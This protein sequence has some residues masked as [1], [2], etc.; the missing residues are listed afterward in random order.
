MVR[1][2]LLNDRFSCRIEFEILDKMLKKLK[3]LSLICVL[4]LVLVSTQPTPSYAVGGIFKLIGKFFDE[5]VNI[6]KSESKVVTKIDNPDPKSLEEQTQEVFKS[7]QSNPIDEVTKT[8]SATTVETA[9]QGS[10]EMISGLKKD[11]FLL[12][13][14]GIRKIKADN[15]LEIA[16]LQEYFEDI[17]FEDTK[18]TSK[19]FSF[20]KL[21]WSGRIYRAE[22]YYKKPK[23]D[24]KMLLECHFN[25]DIF[26]LFIILE[27]KIKEAILDEHISNNRFFSKLK[28]QRLAV[29][30]DENDLK[31]MS[32]FPQ[33]DDEF[34][35]NYFILKNNQDFTATSISE[36]NNPNDMIKLYRQKTKV[37]K[38]NNNQCFKVLKSGLIK[39]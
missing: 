2:Y 34:P 8:K 36:K 7:A 37:S 22:E 16:D 27:D 11:Q 31:I 4:S 33:N 20:Q 14:Q 21:N 25:Q 5:I 9:N 23:L 19:F 29:L 39:E 26:F 10:I 3:K 15:L 38:T 12:K 28:K 24:K 13:F 35:R 6:F 1:N 17:S 32:T 18:K 30:V